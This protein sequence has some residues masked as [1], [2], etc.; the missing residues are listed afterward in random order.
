M[1][2]CDDLHSQYVTEPIILCVIFLYMEKFE[3]VKR[4]NVETLEAVDSLLKPTESSMKTANSP[5]G[6]ASVEYSTD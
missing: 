1:T 6:S 2:L 5:D 3:V 4:D